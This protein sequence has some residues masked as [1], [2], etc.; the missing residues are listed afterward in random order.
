MKVKG[1]LHGATWCVYTHHVYTG[2]RNEAHMSPSQG[3]QLRL[4]NTT[5]PH[6]YCR[7]QCVPSR[8]RVRLL[9]LASPYLDILTEHYRFLYVYGILNQKTTKID[10]IRNKGI[11]DFTR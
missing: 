11:A 1:G 9:L 8:C 5:P 3:S 10:L 6:R 7:D 2:T 4:R